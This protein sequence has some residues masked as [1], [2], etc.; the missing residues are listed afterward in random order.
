MKIGNRF[1]GIV[2][3]LTYL[4]TIVINQNLIY[5][6]IKRTLNSGNVCYHSDHN[7]SSSRLLFKNTKIRITY[8]NI[9]LPVVLCGCDI[10]IGIWTED[11]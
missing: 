3:Q 9:I 11:I 4:G 10:K 8:N 7:I 1:F 6:E 2:A 5:E